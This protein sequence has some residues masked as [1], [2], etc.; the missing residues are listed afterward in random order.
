MIDYEDF[1]GE[2]NEEIEIVICPSCGKE[3]YHPDSFQGNL[4]VI[5]L[6]RCRYCGFQ[7]SYRPDRGDA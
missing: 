5:E 4:G 1:D 3:Q 6:H 7:F 2:C